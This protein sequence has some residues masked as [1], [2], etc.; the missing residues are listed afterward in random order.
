MKGMTFKTPRPGLVRFVTILEIS[1]AFCV[2]LPLASQESSGGGGGDPPSFLLGTF[3]DDY[4]NQFTITAESWA[5]HGSAQY[6]VRHWEPESGFVVLQNHESN[7]GEAGL[8][9]RIDWV[10]LSGMAPWGWAFCMTVY[11]APTPEAAAATPAADTDHPRTGCNG[12]PFSR[13]KP[14]SEGS[15][16]PF[17][18]LAGTRENHER[19]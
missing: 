16:S 13:M 9:T 6:V 7:P 12:F 2:A 5:L 17:H 19:P 1:A 8:W 3:E 10:E 11:D 15:M 18:H 14:S 4:E